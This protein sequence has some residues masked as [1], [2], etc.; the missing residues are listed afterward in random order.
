MSKPFSRIPSALRIPQQTGTSSTGSAASETRSVSPMPS[1]RRMPMPIEL[2]IVPSR[3]RP[4]SVIPR[5]SAYGVSRSARLLSIEPVGIAR[6]WDVVRF[7]RDDDVGVAELF[8]D[9]DVAQRG[10]DHRLGRVPELLF[11][12]ARQRAHVDPDADRRPVFGQLHDFARLLR[13]GD[14][15]GVEAQLGDAGFDARRAPSCD[16]N[17]CRRRSAPASAR[18]CAAFPPHR[19]RLSGDAHDLAARHR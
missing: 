11:Q 19:A 3:G 12:I 1:Q 8:E 13:V 18:R 4:A 5:C 10:H 16:R 9:L 17:G 2:L 7:E 6:S 15:A 14:V